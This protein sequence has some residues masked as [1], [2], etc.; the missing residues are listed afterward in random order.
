MKNYILI[1]HDPLFICQRLKEIDKSYFVLFNC[2]KKQFE[3]HS[4]EQFGGSYCFTVRTGAL[5]ERVITY[6]LRT[7]QE[8]QAEIIAEIDRDNQRLEKSRVKSTIE[9]L[10]EVAM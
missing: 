3:V 4:S 1:E 7:R 5:D 6:A 10:V 8:K 9:K 2:N